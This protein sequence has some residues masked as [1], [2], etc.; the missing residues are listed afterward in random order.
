MSFQAL[1]RAFDVAGM[2]PPHAFLAYLKIAN[3]ADTDGYAL[4]VSAEIA[5]WC[6]MSEIEAAAAVSILASAK[7]I[8]RE[9]PPGNSWFVDPAGR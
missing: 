7:L 6:G 1:A 3:D 9:E 8:R 2:I 4:V 5:A